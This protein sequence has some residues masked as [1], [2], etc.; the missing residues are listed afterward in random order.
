M[1]DGTIVNKVAA[2]PLI[3]FNLE[4]FLPKKV[5][6]V[7]LSQWLESHFVTNSPQQGPIAGPP[8]AT[9][10]VLSPLSG[11]RTGLTPSSSGD[12]GLPALDMW[13]EMQSEMQIDG[14]AGGGCGSE[15]S[16]ASAVVDEEGETFERWRDGV[17]RREMVLEEPDSIGE[18]GAAI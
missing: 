7:D 12:Q 10:N 13:R 8:L 18:A 15:N 6:S 2:S 14:A 11:P 4:D 17:A 5:H 1:N 16:V 3:T 9:P